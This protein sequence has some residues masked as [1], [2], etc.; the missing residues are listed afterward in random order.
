[1]SDVTPEQGAE[2]KIE[3]LLM[4]RYPDE[5]PDDTPKGDAG[6]EPAAETE[7]GDEPEGGEEPDESGDEPEGG[8]EPQAGDEPPEIELDQ[9][10]LAES[11]GVSPEYLDVTDEGKAR[12]RVKVDGEEQFLGLDDLVRGY[13]LDKHAH[14]KAEQLNEERRA[15]H[16]QYTARIQEA[17][18]TQA[19]AEEALAAD[20]ESIDWDTLEKENPEVWAATRIKVQERAQALQQRKAQIMAQKQQA[21][22]EYRQRIAATEAQKL[23]EEIPE[24]KDQAVAEK[25]AKALGSYLIESGYHQQEVANVIDH[26]AMVIARKAM[27]YDKLMKERGEGKKKARKAVRGKP[28]VVKSG[29]RRDKGFERKARQAELRKRV[30]ATGGKPQAVADLIESRMR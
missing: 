27:L 21:D 2:E 9:D 30:R 1:M 20:V 14:Q 5:E 7:T 8:E 22:L 19:L 28:R 24:W 15:L 4:A 26:R 23:T 18:A 11:L 25:E 17:E 29:A 6:E 13:Q 12:I 3:N 16:E 10:L